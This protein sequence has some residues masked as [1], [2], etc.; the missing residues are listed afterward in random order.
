MRVRQLH[1]RQGVAEAA[2]ALVTLLALDDLERGPDQLDG[3]AGV[4]QIADRPRLL[5]KSHLLGAEVEEP[6]DRLVGKI[7]G[8]HTLQ[9]L[10]KGASTLLV[11][12]H[13]FA[14]AGVVHD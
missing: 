2:C 3:E 9:L 11:G 5:R 6:D 1:L 12:G 14:I 7:E 8:M 10:E 4:G 13:A